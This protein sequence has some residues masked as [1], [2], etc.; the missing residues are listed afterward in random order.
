[1][2]VG[3][4]VECINGRADTT[5]I[6]LLISIGY[7][8]PIKGETY[9]V[10]RIQKWGRFTNLLL[11][12]IVNKEVPCNVSGKSITMECGFDVSRFCELLP[13]QP[14]EELIGDALTAKTPVQKLR[15]HVKDWEQTLI[16]H[17]NKNN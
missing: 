17:Y 14:I 16:D 5:G 1:M 7:S 2:Q 8:I 6:S 4:I 11:E 12:E 3:S 10:R 15:Q 9:T 13:P